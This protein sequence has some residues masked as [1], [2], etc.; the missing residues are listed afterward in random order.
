MFADDVSLF[1]T[2]Q[3]KEVAEAAIQEGITEV[4][5]WSRCHEFTLNA[6]KCEVAFF[7]N[8]SKEARWHPSLQLEGTA[9]HTTSLP[10]FLEVTI[11]RALSFGPH[12]AAVV[13][14]HPNRCRV[15]A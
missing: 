15:L 11:D 8:N 9:L 4:A 6:S 12:V 10:K 13:S 14:K 3:N 7:T 2:H 5:E 1:S